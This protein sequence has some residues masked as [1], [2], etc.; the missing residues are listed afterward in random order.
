MV[1]E[2]MKVI[3]N[4]VARG[5]RVTREEG[6]YLLREAPLLELAPLAMAWRYRHNPERRVTFVIDTNLNYTNVCDAYCAFCAFYRTPGQEGEYTYTVEQMMSQFERARDMGCT[7]VLLQGG[8]NDT[9]PLDYY[10]DLVRETRRRFPEIH[11]HFYSAPEIQKVAQ[12]S[13]LSLVEVFDRLREAGLR[14]IPGGGA[15]I[16]SDHVK[17]QISRLWPKA[18]TADWLDVHRAA[19]HVGLRSTATMMYGHVETD[20]DVIDHLEAVR[21]LQDDTGGFTAFIP[22]SYKRD[23]SPLSRKILVEA[24]PNRYLRI[25]ALA[26]IYLDNIVHIQASWFSEGKKTGVVAL[27]FGA[28]DFGGTIFDENVMQEAGHYNRTTVDEIKALIHDAGFAPAQRTTLYDIIRE[29]PNASFP[30]TKPPSGG[31]RSQPEV[32]S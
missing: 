24:G 11:A 12:V 21:R 7:T 13:G 8:L 15:E 32:R 3:R 18:T 28:D 25:I 14:T 5:E 19:H 22:W 30:I 17:A 2:M 29:F 26:R 10:L 4:K 16:L 9:L 31:R 27:G 1:N 6:L 23:N 20:E